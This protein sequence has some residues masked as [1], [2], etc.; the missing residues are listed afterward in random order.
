MGEWLKY[1]APVY[2]HTHTHTC[3]QQDLRRVLKAYAMY[4][5]KTGYCQVYHG[6]SVC[7]WLCVHAEMSLE[8]QWT[9]PPSS[10][11]HLALRS[12]R[13]R[14]LDISRSG[15]L[16][17]AHL[18]LSLIQVHVY[19]YFTHVYMYTYSMDLTHAYYTRVRVYIMH[20]LVAKVYM[21]MTLCIHVCNAIMLELACNY[22][23]F[24]RIVRA[25]TTGISH[26]YYQEHTIHFLLTFVFPRPWHLLQ[27][28]YSC[29]WQQRWVQA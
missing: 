7:D 3:R 12:I 29:T 5:E 28:L 23:C 17:G 24:L 18:C 11:R 13:K 22:A 6:V 21:Y 1:T 20:I 9:N 19:M 25:I 2:T 16:A 26:G 8:R 10:R 15:E 4:N 14:Y 27:P